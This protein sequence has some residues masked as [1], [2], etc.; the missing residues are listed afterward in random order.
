MRYE[1]T[2]AIAKRH[3]ALLALIDRG[4]HSGPE[5][6][7]ELGVSSPTVSRD[8]VFLRCLGYRI[9]SARREGGWAYELTGTPQHRHHTVGGP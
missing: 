2:M 7:E 3:E 4:C 1:H 8:I 9:G 6:A 5:L